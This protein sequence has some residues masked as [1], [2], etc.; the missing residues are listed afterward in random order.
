MTMLHFTFVCECLKESLEI[1]LLLPNE[2]ISVESADGQQ[3][4]LV[5]HGSSQGV[6]EVIRKDWE[7]M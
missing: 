2:V 4:A 5:V 6:D 3:S 7:V 1:G